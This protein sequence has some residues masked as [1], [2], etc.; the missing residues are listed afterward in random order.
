MSK[1][2]LE[3][4]W[5]RNKFQQTIVELG[6]NFLFT[7]RTVHLSCFFSSPTSVTY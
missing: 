6:Y 2:Y 5:G 7:V 1:D 4:M 3:M